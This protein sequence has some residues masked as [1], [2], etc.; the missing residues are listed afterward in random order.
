LPAVLADDA[1]ITQVILN[2]IT[3]AAEAIGDKTGTI[4]VRTSSA[5]L[6][7]QKLESPYIRDAPPAGDYVVLEVEDDGCGMDEATL[8]HIC[9]PFFSTKFTGR[10][11]G[12]ASVLGIAQYRGGSISVSSKLG[13]GTTIRVCLPAKGKIENKRQDR[14][15]DRGIDQALAGGTILLVDDEAGILSM[16]KL[17]LSHSGFSVITASDGMEAVEQFRQHAAD[18]MLIVMDITMPRMDGREAYTLIREM[19][20]AIPVIMSSGY[21]RTRFEEDFRDA[22]LVTFLPKPYNRSQ[23]NT[24]IQKAFPPER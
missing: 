5:Y 10:G 14:E 21:S 18:I 24:A 13:T 20:P 9:D 16:S 8:A 3:N 7:D 2:L 12:M 22:P 17:L 15:A 11:L 6:N 1:Q 19:D 4:T 23:L